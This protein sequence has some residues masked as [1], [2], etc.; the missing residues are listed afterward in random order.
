M[1][2]ERCSP[3]GALANRARAPIMRAPALGWRGSRL[4]RHKWRPGRGALVSDGG[5]SRRFARRRFHG[6][7]G[8]GPRETSDARAGHSH[9]AQAAIRRENASAGDERRFAIVFVARLT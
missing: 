5:A 2:R 9:S 7:R 3:N 4:A 6:S 8:L 1:S